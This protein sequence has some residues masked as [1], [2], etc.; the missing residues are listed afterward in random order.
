MRKNPLEE[1]RA[2]VEVARRILD[3][4]GAPQASDSLQRALDTIIRERSIEQV[5]KPAW[6]NDV[7][8]IVVPNDIPYVIRP[9]NEVEAARAQHE[10]KEPS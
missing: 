1:L 6:T 7:R 5:V 3:T 9:A 8:I 10:Y 4:A 2:A